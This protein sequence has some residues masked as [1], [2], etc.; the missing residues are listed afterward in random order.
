M[1]KIIF[2]EDI[3][4]LSLCAR[5]SSYI[6]DAEKEGWETLGGQTLV[7]KNEKFYMAQAIIK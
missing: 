3:I 6:S 2:L 4:F 1:Y 5:M 7:V